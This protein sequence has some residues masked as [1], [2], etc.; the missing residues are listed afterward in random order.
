MPNTSKISFAGLP[1]M[2]PAY[3][4]VLTSSKPYSAPEGTAV[5]P[6]ELEVRKIKL[7]QAH[8][9]RYRE[10]CGVPPG[11]ALPPAYLHT[12]AMPV[13]M[14][15]FI[16]EKFP[17]K[18]LGLIH[19]RN[20]IRVFQT[21]SL[22]VPLQLT[23]L[24]NTMRLT[25]FGQEYDFTTRYT[26][27]GEVV[28]EE[29]STMFARGNA[30]PKEGTKRPSIERSAHPAAGVS[31]DTLE[32]AENTGWRYARVSGD[33]NPIHLTARTAKMFGFKQAVAHG[34]WSMGRCLGSAAPHLP[35]GRIQVDTQF[36]LP[37]YLPS[38]ALARTWSVGNGVDIAMCTPRGDRLH[39]AMQARS[40]E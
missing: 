5:T 15:L 25:D 11:S 1:S 28:W 32:I 4:R 24:F 38:Q 8:L 40:I 12:V 37:V 3:A 17:V 27:E 14:Q 33:F 26:A 10:I 22:N 13:H 36:K 35:T 29:V 31:T 39:L 7:S 30:A 23:V 20:T 2:V 19:L 9:Q 34:M 6:V 21:V 16:A 18:V